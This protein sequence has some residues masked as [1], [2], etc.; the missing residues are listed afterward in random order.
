MKLKSAHNL[1]T[2]D[3]ILHL[4]V[5]GTATKT[6]REEKVE[7]EDLDVNL[8]LISNFRWYY[9]GLYPAAN[10]HLEGTERESSGVI[11][12]GLEW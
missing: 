5:H 4:S 8:R 9:S 7:G 2:V 11:P 3:I 6:T 10:K 12:L 1:C